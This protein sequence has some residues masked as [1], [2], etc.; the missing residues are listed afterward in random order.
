MT[1][2]WDKGEPL[3][4]VIERFTVGHDPELDLKL[5]AFDA[6]GSAAHARML[7]RVGLLPAAEEQQINRVLRTIA[8]EVRDGTFLITRA[9]EDC[10]TA[11]ENRL[12]VELGD[13]GRR[14][15]TGRSRNDQVIAAL[16]LFAREAV[17]TI[18]SN[19]AELVEQ[20]CDL[21]EEH[22][23]VSVP[24]YTHTRQAMPSTL[25]LLFGAFAE[26]LI[27]NVPWLKAAHGHVN[28]SPLGSASGFGVSLPI[29]R[30]LTAKLLRFERVQR[31]VIAV[32]NDRGKT[33]HLVLEACAA[34]A[35][36]LARLASDL[37]WYS[38][39]E[40]DYI[41]LASSV[42][43]GSSIMPQ[44]RNPD[45]LEL[46]RATGAR[47]RSRS[48]EIS[49]VYAPLSSG[50]HRDLQ[51]T[52]EPFLSGL[53]A[54][55]DVIRVMGKVLE[56]IEVHPE[57]CLEAFHPAIGATDAMSQRIIAGQ[58]MREAY[59]EIG[60][61]P[62]AAYQGEVAEAWRGREHIGAPG[63]YDLRPTRE[64][65]AETLGWVRARRS[66]MD[67]AWADLLGID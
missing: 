7:A 35:L 52:K 38:S 59:Q 61:D 67:K 47:L 41:S 9:E 17:V 14:I 49:A 28:R 22:R 55:L 48:S 3:D 51:H 12:T 36:D 45:A 42:T 13:A 34:P 31:N 53:R 21:S 10:H 19:L 40:L 66:K 23:E 62:A 43:T 32:Q 25:G 37:I 15:H 57:R 33:E 27:D 20:L 26:G 64:I 29:D 24:G 8:A 2:L 50:Y 11:I 16:R 54:A 30:E 44:K 63:A 6:L 1:R 4:E 5:A 65:V 56:S 18:T 39:D 46:V 60:K 58:P